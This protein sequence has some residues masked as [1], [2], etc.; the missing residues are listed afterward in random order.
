[1][2]QVSSALEVLVSG[3]VSPQLVINIIMFVGG[4]LVKDFKGEAVGLFFS[5]LRASPTKEAFCLGLVAQKK[6]DLDGGRTSLEGPA[7]T[8]LAPA[9][10]SQPA[11]DCC[12]YRRFVL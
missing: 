1:V 6:M 9:P 11:S 7:S 2:A 3:R 4:D 8:Q 5:M 12:I 10:Y